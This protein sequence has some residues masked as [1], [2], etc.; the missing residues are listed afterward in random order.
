MSAQVLIGMVGPA[1]RP[2]RASRLGAARAV[3]L[4][5]RGVA[6]GGQPSGGVLAARAAAVV[7][8]IGGF[9]GCCI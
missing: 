5:Q 4:F 8:D 1:F 6:A 2:V 7:L 3:L 9:Y